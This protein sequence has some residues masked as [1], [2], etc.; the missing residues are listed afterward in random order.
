M[1]FLVEAGLVMLL[2][3]MML[4]LLLLTAGR[5]TLVGVRFIWLLFTVEILLE[6]NL[7][8]R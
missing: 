4:L 8:R 1:V 2:G 5:V 3:I 7:T 6:E